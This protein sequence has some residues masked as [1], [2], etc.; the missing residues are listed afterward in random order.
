MYCKQQQDSAHEQVGKKH[1]APVVPEMIDCRC[2]QEFKCPRQAKQAQKSDFTQV[3][4][5]LA[6][7]YREDIVENAQWK[8]LGK[9]EDADPEQF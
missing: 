8:A 7:V 4:P 2:P 5:L 3:N 6:E 9:I 1:P